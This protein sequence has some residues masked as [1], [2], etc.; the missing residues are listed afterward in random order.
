MILELKIHTKNRNV[1]MYSCTNFQEH[2]ERD[3]EDMRV[4]TRAITK[5]SL[6]CIFQEL[7]FSTKPLVKI[8]LYKNGLVQPP[9]S[10]SLSFVLV[11]SVCCISY[12][13]LFKE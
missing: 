13:L 1:C 9:T 2:L 7:S 6:V 3:K 8:G 10:I 5:L 12:S 4:Y 11:I